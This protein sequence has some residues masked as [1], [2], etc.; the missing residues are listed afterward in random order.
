[1]SAASELTQRAAAGGNGRA[2]A[3]EA[4]LRFAEATVRL[5][6]ETAPIERFDAEREALRRTQPSAAARARADEIYERALHMRGL[7]VD[8]RRREAELGAL[9]DTA[10]D[11]TAR[12]D[13]DAILAEICRRVRLLL[14]TDA[15]WIT[16]VDAERGDTY[17]CMTDGILTDG[18]VRRF[19]LSSGTG[20]GGLVLQTGSAA[21]TDDYLADQR[22]A[23]AAPIDQNAREEGFSAMLGA[24][25]KRG[26]ELLGI[27][28][29]GNRGPRRFATH[30]VTLLQTLADHAAIAIA[31]AHLLSRALAASAELREA[32]RLIHRNAELVR[33]S[34][35]LQMRLSRLVLDGVELRELLAPVTEL[36]GGRVVMVDSERRVIAAH[37]AP[38]D[39]LDD[40]VMQEG[41]A[42]GDDALPEEL[43]RA[44]AAAQQE[45][46]VL[47]A[48]G[49]DD[50]LP[51]VVAPMLTRSE[52]LGALLLA[53]ASV[54]DGDAQLLEAAA[55]PLALFL[56]NARSQAQAE[57][58]VRG[59]L[60]D[61]LIADTVADPEVLARRARQLGWS[62]D[63]RY[64]LV[65][66]DANDGESRWA[67]LRA[68][69]AT[70]ES[71]GFM[72]EHAD[73]LVLAL[74]GTSADDVAARVTRALRTP[75]APPPTIAVAGPAEG[76]EHVAGV[77]R[78]ARQALA[79][80]LA[81][82][83]RGSTV[84]ADRA[85]A[86]GIV[87]GSAQPDQLERFIR[88]M[89]GPLLDYDAERGS[90][91]VATLDAWFAQDGHMANTA[92]AVFVHV[93]T[94][95][96]RME[97]IDALLGDGWRSSDARL[98]LQ[99]ALRLRQLADAVGGH[100]P[101]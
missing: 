36:L 89:L 101:R 41:S 29:T 11:L 42:I 46:R 34:A 77:Y 23:H 79:L 61:D 96:K 78:E 50:R 44:I 73:T 100:P 39:S 2:S 98:Q 80:T 51:R 91:L 27:V 69:R 66:V 86:Y 52:P 62:P 87:F 70:A 88:Q 54:E 24:P 13:L 1:V 35:E 64:V 26:E 75:D 38:T 18:P 15:A 48:I 28:I 49:T 63:G 17:H 9:I 97:R 84:S 5:V 12:H 45:E 47:T 3:S 58:V 65:V 30:D 85:D 25:M 72:T 95:Y 82:G 8:H 40:A 55:L 76:I 37:G 7:L 21:W 6:E 53:K 93:N 90:D 60:L 32:N 68:S 10:A 74:P 57:R 33:R 59:E 81:L 83:R 43:A 99:L 31:N 22:F 4:M 92:K 16:L 94:L 19:R 14:G 67:R 71:H 56:A 20:L